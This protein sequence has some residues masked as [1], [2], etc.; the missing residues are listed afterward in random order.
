MRIDTARMK[1]LRLSRALSLRALARASGLGADTVVEIEAGK[2]SPHP[3]TVGRL[4]EALGVEPAELIDW[5]AEDL[6]EDE[7]KAA[8]LAA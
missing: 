8:P 1:R 2:R 4:A 7:G 6:A 3:R 5:E